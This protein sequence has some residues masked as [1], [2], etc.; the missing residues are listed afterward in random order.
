VRER[1]SDNDMDIDRAPAVCLSLGAR[2]IE[3]GRD[4]DTYIYIYR[5]I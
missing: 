4:G 3:T 2:G 5:E 1:D